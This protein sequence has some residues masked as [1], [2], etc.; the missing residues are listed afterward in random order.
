MYTRWHTVQTL[1]ALMNR[2]LKGS[3]VDEAKY[4]CQMDIP[5]GYDDKDDIN[6]A[7]KR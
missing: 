5:H 6:D 7:A 4:S 3:S 1:A 2:T